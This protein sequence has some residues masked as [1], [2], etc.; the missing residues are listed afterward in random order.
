[1]SASFLPGLGLG[2]SLILAIGAQNAF[3]LRQGL[4]R[5]HVFAVCLTC[6]L[7][8]ALLIGLGVTSLKAIS[9]ALPLAE[10]IL[11]FGGAAFLL[12]YGARSFR[13]AFGP[14]GRLLPEEGARS[15]SLGRALGTALV[16]TFAN[17]HVYLD[18][19]VLVGTVST[20]YA[21]PVAFGGGAALAS[22]LFFFALGYGARW[23]RPIFA[24]PRSWQV[25]E[26]CIGIV[27]TTLGLK[28]AFGI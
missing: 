8:D 9:S 14:S 3:V 24:R 5:E 17:P 11:R 7:S 13:A 10:P 2:L 26:F 18:T 25:L 27:M 1:M 4:R 22:F 28:L 12:A 15:R 19:V 21:D 23:L 20:R 6:S 16:L